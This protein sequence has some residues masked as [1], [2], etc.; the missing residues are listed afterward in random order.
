MKNKL[1]TALII[2]C[3]VFLSVGA[4]V[5][6]VYL[7]PYWQNRRQQ[8]QAAESFTLGVTPAPRTTPAP[9]LPPVTAPAE[10]AEPAET[11]PIRV[12]FEALQAINPD[13]IGWIYCPDT[14][15]N[16]PILQGQSNDDYLYTNYEKQS[17]GAGSIFEDAL[18][19]R[20]FQDPSSI[21]YG[22]HMAD[23]SM[24]ATLDR[25]QRQTYFDEHPVMWILTPGQDYKVEL[26]SAYTVSAYADTYLIYRG[27]GPEFSA[28]LRE[29][30]G[31]SEIE[32]GVD[33]Q[34]DDHFVLLSTCA[35][36]FEDARSVI[37]G[38]LVPVA[39]APDDAALQEIP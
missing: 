8:T 34:E 17:S 33:W 12:D 9:A 16:Y 15:I 26:F 20:G 23:G 3:L 1:R 36:S 5:A 35:Y 2:Y 27:Y 24:F 10:S 6:G 38:R 18:N 31:K 29:A 14:V 25:W 30:A 13:I 19:L 4:V 11:A 22:H 28:W 7:F 37:H 32:S 21:L 39:D